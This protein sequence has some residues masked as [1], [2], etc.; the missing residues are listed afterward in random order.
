MLGTFIDTIIVCSITGLVIIT[1]GAWT[2]GKPIITARFR[3]FL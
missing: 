1:S 3:I 2:S